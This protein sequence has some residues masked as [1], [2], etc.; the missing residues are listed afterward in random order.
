MSL[1]YSIIIVI[2]AF[3]IIFFDAR[4]QKIPLWLVI[5]NYVTLSLL[6]N[7]Y[8]LIGLIVILVLK[9]FDK[10]IDIVYIVLLSICLLLRHDSRYLMC[11]MPLFIQIMTSRKERI[12]F[13]ISI[14]LSC[15]ILTALEILEV[16]T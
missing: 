11:I 7:P 5:L 6:V 3:A 4:Y 12:S 1:V 9:K 10:P 13:M 8:L 15:I 16:L 14:E 2:T